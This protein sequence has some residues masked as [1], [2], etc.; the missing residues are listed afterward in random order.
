MDAEPL[1][2]SSAQ[3]LNTGLVMVD[4]LDRRHVTVKEDDRN[5]MCQPF[6]DIERMQYRRRCY[7]SR[8]SNVVMADIDIEEQRTAS[9]PHRVRQQDPRQRRFPGITTADNHDARA[10]GGRFAKCINLR[11]QVDILAHW[12]LVR[13]INDRGSPF[14]L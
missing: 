8:N 7:R 11:M 4:V 2:D 6:L 5:A 9:G 1:I 3:L 14:N 10:V 13:Y 12:R